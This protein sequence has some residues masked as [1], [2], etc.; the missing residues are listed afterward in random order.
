MS[1][2]TGT[3]QNNEKLGAVAPLLR[4]IVIGTII[5]LGFGLIM[6]VVSNGFV[7]GV[8]ALLSTK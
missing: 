2:G 6:A 8:K 3:S 7:H 4:F 5:G 1:V